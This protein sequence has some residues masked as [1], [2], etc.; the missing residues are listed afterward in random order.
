MCKVWLWKT[1]NH[2]KN[3]AMGQYKARLQEV[4]FMNWTCPFAKIQVS[5]HG[6]VYLLVVW[7]HNEVST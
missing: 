2:G 1:E 6:Y 3:S 5:K 7:L 4:W